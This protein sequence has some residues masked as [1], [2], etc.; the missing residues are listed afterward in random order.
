M[1]G[2]LELLAHDEEGPTKV[3]HRIYPQN[4]MLAFFKVG[5]DTFHQVSKK[6]N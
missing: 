4:N 2:A 3:E 5:T 6:S 1:G